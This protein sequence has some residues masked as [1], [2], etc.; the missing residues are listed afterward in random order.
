MLSKG[1]QPVIQK[2]PTLIEEASDLIRSLGEGNERSIEALEELG[3]RLRQGRFHLAVLGQF[4]RGKSTFLNALLG[5]TILPSAVVPLTAIPTFI[6]HGE[7]LRCSVFFLEE[8]GPVEVS[9]SG[10]EE[11]KSFLAT[12]VTEEGNPNNTMGVERVEVFHPSEIL[13]KG[14]VLIDT[15]GIG[16]TFRHNTEAT[17]N[18]LPQCDA[19]VFL[20]SA[21]PPITEV[22]VQFLKEV[23]ARVAR[24]FF[25]LNKVDYLSEDD[26]AHAL[27]FLRKVLEEQ[28]GVEDNP[29]IFCISARRGLEAR[30]IEDKDLWENSG[31]MDIERHL[32]EFLASEKNQALGEAIRKKSC[33]IVGECLMR[34][35]LSLRTLQL[36]LE[37]LQN[38][39]D[40]FKVE[41]GEAEIQRVAAADLLAGDRKRMHAFL[42]GYAEEIR[43]KA[44][45]YLGGLVQGVFDNDPGAGQDEV[46]EALEEAIP[47]FFEHQVGEA[48]DLFRGRMTQ[49]LRPHQQRA[50][51]LIESIRKT[52]AELFEVPYQAP[53]S[54]DAFEMV[55]QPYWI[56]HKWSNTFAPIQS[57]LAEKFMPAEAWRKQLA[58]RLLSQTEE[59]VVPNVENLRWAIFQSIDQTFLRFGST[60]DRR[61][62][63]TVEA[64][65]GAVRAALE[66][67]RVHSETVAEEAANT[68]AVVE[69]LE[70]IRAE[71][72]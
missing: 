32:L 40:L 38:R 48:M 53:E 15:P 50:D 51:G 46:K 54:S 20:V 64:T 14:V 2:L 34:G 22:E 62:S 45:E 7:R 41:I 52:A 35:R 70:E 63:E 68:G 17:L 47:G 36:P 4:K 58:R 59:L 24:L 37:D 1:Q 13:G 71:L 31:L 8:K 57:G 69:G 9:P 72:A 66:K 43:E 3:D 16:S 10:S 26:C 49:T 42:E 39:L 6:S 25:I 65:H 60:L 28:A 27:G 67:R 30:E 23:K 44:R 29:P 55:R 56:T 33:D 18:F 61:L 11:L 19:A 12:Y 21:D 5:E